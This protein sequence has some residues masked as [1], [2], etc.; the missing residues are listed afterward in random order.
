LKNTPK[1]FLKNDSI[2]IGPHAT[3]TMC[4]VNE[5]STSKVRQRSMESDSIIYRDSII[6]KHGESVIIN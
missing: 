4:Y 6:I 3:I 5:D 2:C 1:T